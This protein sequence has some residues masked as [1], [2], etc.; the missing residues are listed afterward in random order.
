MKHYLS[1]IMLRDNADEK[2]L[3]CCD[4]Y[5]K[6]NQKCTSLNLLLVKSYVYSGYTFK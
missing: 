4:C 5:T 6:R 2:F 3:L 1:I